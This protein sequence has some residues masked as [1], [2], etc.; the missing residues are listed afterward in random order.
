[1]ARERVDRR[2]VIIR[3]EHL[4]AGYDDVVVLNDISFNVHR[5]EIFFIL[6]GSG[7]GKSTL[8]K[9]MIGLY[10]PSRGVVMINGRDI[11]SAGGHERIGVLKNFGVMYQNGALFGSMTIL[12][13]VR[14]PLEE[15][16]DMPSEAMDVI[17]RMKLQLV[18]LED[19][20][21]QMP[22]E[23]SGGM[24]KRAALARAMALDPGILFLD[25]PTSGLDPILSAELDQLVLRLSETLGITFVVVSHALQSVYSIADRVILLDKGTREVIAEGTPAELRDHGNEVVRRFLN[26]R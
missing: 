9:N 10:R 19:V 20:G 15:W 12:E 4:T 17:A 14:L 8:M 23:L 6:G 1:M 22:A 2:Q 16:T 7:S 21:F 5:G 13:N 25:E 11:V 3:V 26:P 18:G 24:Q